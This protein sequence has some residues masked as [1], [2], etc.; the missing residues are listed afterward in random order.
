MQSGRIG[1][2]E[3]IDDTEGKG[4]EE[5]EERLNENEAKTRAILLEMV[6]SRHQVA[7]WLAGLRAETLC[8]PSRWG[9]CPTQTS[10]PRRTCCLSASSTRSPPTRTW[11]SSSLA[12]E[13]SGGGAVCLEALLVVLTERIHGVVL[14]VWCSCEIIRDWKSGDSLCYAFIEFDKVRIGSL[15]Q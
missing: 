3:V 12:S 5:L 15:H 14:C 10:D 4:E 11:R 9:I 2:D 6:S 8:S 13:P 7:L 1:A